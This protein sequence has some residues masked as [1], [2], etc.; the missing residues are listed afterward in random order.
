LLFDGGLISLG[1][2]PSEIFNFRGKSVHEIQAVNE[3]LCVRKSRLPSKSRTE[4][5]TTHLG[6]PFSIDFHKR[7]I[8]L[9]APRT[10]LAAKA[11]KKFNLCAFSSSNGV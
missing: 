4:I 8:E 11:L 10:Q 1:C 3:F 6:L 5:S 2:C 7:V 9:M